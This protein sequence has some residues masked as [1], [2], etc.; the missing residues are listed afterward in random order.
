MLVEACPN[1]KEP[2]LLA[3]EAAPK[4]FALV[5]VGAEETDW[6]KTGPELNP[7]WLKEKPLAGLL[8]ACPKAGACP[9][10]VCPKTAGAE[11]PNVG[12]PNPELLAC[13]VAVAV[14]LAAT[15]PNTG[16]GVAED[17]VAVLLESWLNAELELAAGGC[18]KTEEPEVA[19]PNTAVSVAEAG[20]LLEAVLEVLGVPDASL[21]AEPAPRRT[22]A[23]TAACPGP[24]KVEAGAVASVLLSGPPGATGVA[25]VDATRLAA[26]AGGLGLLSVACTRTGSVLTGSEV[27]REAWGGWV[28]CGCPGREGADAETSLWPD[29]SGTADGVAS[30]MLLPEDT[31]REEVDAELRRPPN[32]KVGKDA[33]REGATEVDV[34]AADDTVLLLVCWFPNEK[35][36]LLPARDA[37]PKLMSPEGP[38]LVR[39]R[40]PKTAAEELLVLTPR[41]ETGVAGAGATEDVTVGS[42]GFPNTEVLGKLN[43]EGL[44]GWAP[45]RLVDEALLTGFAESSAWP[46]RSPEKLP[47]VSPVREPGNRNSPSLDVGVSNLLEAVDTVIPEE[48]AG[49]LLGG[50]ESPGEAVVTEVLGADMAPVGGELPGMVSQKGLPPPPNENASSWFGSLMGGTDPGVAVGLQDGADVTVPKAKAVPDE[51]NEKGL[52]SCPTADGVGVTVD[53]VLA[54]PGP[55]VLSPEDN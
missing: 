36:V 13:G 7:G 31:G 52:L 19:V 32:D 27:C 5:D 12:L 42:I 22:A 11:A 43:P 17:A 23:A 39:G 35:L 9:N 54:V 40:L 16:V 20:A 46:T 51:A 41:D 14:L 8:V 48:A 37:P 45:A 33:G 18:V 55:A 3:L 53:S 38:A 28:D 6:P 26:D 34:G 44:G 47:S 29:F 1:E 2:G 25:S 24:A 49:L 30:S 21:A 10:A 4:T 15:C 50:T